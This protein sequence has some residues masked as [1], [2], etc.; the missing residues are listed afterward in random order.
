M[1]AR[2]AIEVTLIRAW[3]YLLRL[4]ASGEAEPGGDLGAG[5]VAV[6]E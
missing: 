4:V 2:K 6:R 1:S 5:V 3:K